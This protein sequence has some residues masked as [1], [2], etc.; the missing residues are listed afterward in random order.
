M[1]HRYIAFILI[2]FCLDHSSAFAQ[3]TN[4]FDKLNQYEKRFSSQEL[5]DT[6]SSIPYGAMVDDLNASETWFRKAINSAHLIHDDNRVADISS[7]LATVFYLQGKYDSST[8]YNL[9]AIKLYDHLSMD[10][11]KGEVLCE[12]GYQTKRRD[13]DLA[14]RYFREGIFLL[15]KNNASEEMKSHAY[16][17][18]GVL[19]EMQNDLDSAGY[20]YNEAL[21]RKEAANDSVAIPYSLNKI[22]QL[23]LIKKNY[24]VA[25]TYFDKAYEM[26]KHLKNAFG[27]A[28]NETFYGDLYV[29]SEEWDKAIEWYQ[30]SNSSAEQLKYPMLLQYNYEQLVICFEKT[31]RY[32]DALDVARKS[33]ELKDELLNEKNS[34]VILELEERYDSAEKDRNISKLEADAAKKK[35]T[36]Y[37]VIATAIILLLVAFVYIVNA[38]RKARATRDA[39]II[40]EREAGLRAVFDATEDE[41]KRIAK[42]L[43]DGLGQQLSGL[44]LSW[45]GLENKI[46]TNAPEQSERLKQLTLILDEACAEVRSISHTMMPKV[47]QEKGLLAAIE[48]MVRKSLGLTSIRFQIEHFKVEDVRFAER[49]ELS[50]YRICQELI[51]NIIKHSKASEVTIQLM[52]S[53]G[54]LILIVE[55]NGIGFNHAKSKDG[56]GMMNI[57]SRL[58]T[59]KGEADIEP[60][61]ECGVVATIRVPVE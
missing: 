51:N 53:K 48:E 46:A 33:A 58:N 8:Y 57:S 60:G 15:E 7:R 37:I 35:F 44:R 49:I 41:R 13:L 26:R 4:Y 12:L 9:E 22:A 1:S 30:K 14:F 55:D 59:V 24:V 19:F 16:D 40:E 2:V 10:L 38:K 27:L 3:E 29:A 25:K 20:Y 17:N 45:E 21:I 31:A 34:R 42:D 32:K 54:H 6:I 5:I 39:A 11:K 36:I 52:R 18:Y 50:I 61:P 23:N 47:L 56:I 28:E 43:H